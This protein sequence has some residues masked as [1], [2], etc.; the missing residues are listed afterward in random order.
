VLASILSS[1]K[2]LGI[3]CDIGMYASF[4]GPVR[5]HLAR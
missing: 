2:T 5:H 3:V 4:F 1:D